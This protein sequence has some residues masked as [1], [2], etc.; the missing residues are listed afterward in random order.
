MTTLGLVLVAAG[1]ALIALAAW[2]ARVPLAT[3]RHLDATAANLKRYDEWRGGRLEIEDAGPTGA[4]VMRSQMRQR[5]LLWI[6]VG[7]AG[8]V[9]VVIGLLQR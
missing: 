2:M 9:L 7:V 1:I 5:L 4:D 3:I 6:A 8:A